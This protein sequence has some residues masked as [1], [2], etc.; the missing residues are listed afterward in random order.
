M[1]A[2]ESLPIPADLQTFAVQVALGGLCVSAIALVVGRLLRHRAE[3]L[4]YGILLT[5]VMGLLAVPALVGLGRACQAALPEFTPPGEDEIV[6][7][8]AEMLPDVLNRPP[9][10]PPA[11][12]PPPLVW[13][14]VGAGLL[15]LWLLGTAI[16]T[17]R[18]LR[19]LYRQSRALAGVPWRAE[20]WTDERRALLARQLGLTRFP[21]VYLS[22]AVPMPMVIGIWR[23][24][25]VLPEPAPA[26]WQQPQ[27][28]AVLLHEAAHI[29]RGDHWAV[30]A[31]RSAAILFWWCPLVHI[32][33]RRLDALREHICD[34]CAVQGTCDRIAY[35]ELLVDSAE[36]FLR[37]TALGAPLGLLDS[38][39]G[40]LEARVSRL[41]EKERPTMTRLSLP[42]KLLGAAGLVTVCLLTAAGTAFSGGQNA[43]PKRIQIKI[44]IDG[45][46]IDLSDAHVWQQVEA[47]Q[48]K[49]AEAQ[50]E[51]KVHGA[52]KPGQLGD[53]WKALAFSPDGKILATGDGKKIVMWDAGTG[54]L[55]VQGDQVK[56][57]AKAA[58]RVVTQA[59]QKADPRIEELVKQAEAI[60]PGSGDAIRKALQT[61]P[62]PAEVRTTK[63]HKLVV[64]GPGRVQV[65]GTDAAGKKVI[66]L[67][68]DG[69]KILQLNEL[70]L[71]KLV[72][73]GI[74]MHFKLDG[75]KQKIDEKAVE[76]LHIEL[77]NKA[78]KGTGSDKKAAPMPPAPDLEALSRHI[79]R[80]HAELEDLRKRLEAG[81]K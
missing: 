68:I 38:A 47:A 31:Q 33:A 25:I 3:P 69:D 58:W 10:D 59:E 11:E 18:L 51:L 63:E 27:W 19:A 74:Q 14:L 39:R 42:G 12:D 64:P 53:A 7:V 55:L 54:K 44:I 5:G 40:G 36:H 75:A 13:Q 66:I 73:K 30:L 23:P 24:T 28:E 6:R 26:A 22:P 65:W 60:K 71:H 61:A 57:E 62:K 81:K 21:A 2:L 46:E 77:L 9:V 37:L 1:N 56:P 17:G 52:L 32:L 45:K 79:E 15:A 72:D 34:D 50:I 80:L 41:L 49:A 70:D 76:K 43:P 8:P 78:V 29:A 48:K 16:G 20:F 35:A 67:A 4:R